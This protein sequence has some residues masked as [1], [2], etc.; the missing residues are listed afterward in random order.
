[1]TATLA[2]KDT[3]PAYPVEVKVRVEKFRQE[4]TIHRMFVCDAT[5]FATIAIF[6]DL[7]QPIVEGKCYSFMVSLGKEFRGQRDLVM[8]GSSYPYSEIPP[9]RVPDDPVSVTSAVIQPGYRYC[10]RAHVR[11][12]GVKKFARD[13][14]T[15][16]LWTITLSDGK[17]QCPVKI[18]GDSTDPLPHVRDGLYD[19]Y[20][21]SYVPSQNSQYPIGHFDAK[22]ARW[23]CIEPK[24]VQ[25]S[26]PLSPAPEPSS[27][28]VPT[29]EPSPAP[30][31]VPVYEPP[32]PANF[33]RRIVD[34]I[35][36]APHLPADCAGIFL[37]LGEIRLFITELEKIFASA[38]E[39]EK[40]HGAGSFYKNADAIDTLAVLRDGSVSTLDIAGASVNFGIDVFEAIRAVAP[41]RRE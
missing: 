26:I 24:T 2:N 5:G 14:R 18:W 41:V 15:L 27:P 3:F 36:G 19:I 7:Q 39:Y 35:G 8:N 28:C 37:S 40:I 21:L 30:E 29:P 34:A 31:P 1:M 13:D 10:V 23:V 33:P 20:C 22:N 16:Y 17:T 6:G 38:V 25:S 4:K 12:D 9:I 32:K 11:K